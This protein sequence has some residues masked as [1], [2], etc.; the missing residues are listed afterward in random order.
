MKDKVVNQAVLGKGCCKLFVQG[1][2]WEAG[3]F[4]AELLKVVLGKLVVLKL[5][6]I[7]GKICLKLLF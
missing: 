1:L 7:C 3:L 6:L 2:L 5:P 4:E